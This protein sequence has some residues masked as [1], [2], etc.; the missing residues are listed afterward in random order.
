MR[1]ATPF[2]F[3]TRCYV[4]LRF[5]PPSLSIACRVMLLV[6]YRRCSLVLASTTSTSSHTDCSADAAHSGR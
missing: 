4:P 1:V 2:A 5:L 3:L 6:C